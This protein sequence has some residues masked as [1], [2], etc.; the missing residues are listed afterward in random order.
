[1]LFLIFLLILFLS[2]TYESYE[3]LSHYDSIKV[4][5]DTKVY[6]D[7]SSFLYGDLISIE[8]GL[9]YSNSGLTS[10]KTYTY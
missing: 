9:D 1:M 6:I 3:K 8:I 2:Y 10:R 4:I 5:P 7:I